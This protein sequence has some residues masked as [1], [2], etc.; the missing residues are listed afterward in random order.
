MSVTTTLEQ[1]ADSSRAALVAA[2]ELQGLD[3]S[4]AELIYDALNRVYRLPDAGAVG[5][6]HLRGTL[7]DAQRRVR[8]ACALLAAGIPTAAP[9]G[10]LDEPVVVDGTVVSFTEDLG[11][12]QPSPGQFGEL[13]ARLHRIPPL[14]GIGLPHMDKIARAAARIGRLGPEALTDRQR[15]LLRRRLAQAADTYGRVNWSRPCTV[16]GDVG[17]NNFLLTKDRGTALIDLESMSIGHPETDQAAPAWAVGAFGLDPSYYQQFAQ[18]YG[19]DITTVDG[20]K[21]FA[22][23]VPIFGIMSCLSY[24]EVS[25]TRPDVRPEAELRLE[26]ILS[27]TPQPWN[28]TVDP[29]L[30]PTH[31]S[32]R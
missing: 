9:V 20:G 25:R 15:L 27:G 30:A 17:K 26:T 7:A 4:G 19:Y 32:T 28:W 6:V 23:L 31:A 3:P 13:L 11:R 1:R 12:R 16:H 29:I 2:A 14:T 18:G 8:A 5:K 21:P 22:A 24:L 10:C